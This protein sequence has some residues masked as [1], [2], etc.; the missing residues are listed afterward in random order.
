MK[1]VLE[2]SNHPFRMC[3]LCKL[4]RGLGR[5]LTTTL[6][7]KLA[8]ASLIQF[9]LREN[10][11]T[12]TTFAVVWSRPNCVFAFFFFFLCIWSS[13]ISI[14]LAL[15]GKEKTHTYNVFVL[16]ITT[17]NW[18]L[19]RRSSTTGNPALFLLDRQFYQNK[20]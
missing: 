15:T 5:C 14:L 2:Q 12:V 18:E 4:K 11:V 10:A 9:P 16:N 13:F 8:R 1:A 7:A 6:R 20:T 19:I 3:T 17:E